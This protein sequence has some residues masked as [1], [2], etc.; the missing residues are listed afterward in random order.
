MFTKNTI[1]LEEFVDRVF[2]EDILA[3]CNPPK[4]RVSRGHTSIP[5]HI[6]MRAFLSKLKMCISLNSYTHGYVIVW[7]QEGTRSLLWCIDTPM[8]VDLAFDVADV[9]SPTTRCIPRS[10]AVH[11]LA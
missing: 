2:N 8:C 7:I 5:H 3:K 9:L 6:D 1:A 11:R 10:T 4:E